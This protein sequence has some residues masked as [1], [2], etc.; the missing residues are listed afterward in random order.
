[1]SGIRA[2]AFTVVGGSVLR[3][4]LIC[5]NW[6]WVLERGVCVCLQA[7]WG[8]GVI[9]PDQAFRRQGDLVFSQRASA[10]WWNGSCIL[11]AGSVRL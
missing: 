10:L 8:G 6:K 1:M 2:V 7:Q 3:S 4:P 5:G 9:S 11:G